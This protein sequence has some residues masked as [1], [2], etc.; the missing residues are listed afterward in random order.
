MQDTPVFLELFHVFALL[1]HGASVNA[2]GNRALAGD[3]I[4]DGLGHPVGLVPCSRCL[5]IQSARDIAALRPETT[6]YLVELFE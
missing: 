6:A 3:R 4:T 2:R 5:P 1:R